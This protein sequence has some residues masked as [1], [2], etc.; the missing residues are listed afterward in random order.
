MNQSLWPEVGAEGS[1]VGHLGGHPWVEV[2][3]EE[4]GCPL[5]VEVEGNWRAGFAGGAQVLWNPWQPREEG[6]VGRELVAG[7]SQSIVGMEVEE[8]SY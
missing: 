8:G 5:Q 2:A 6:M 1:Q 3:V 7:E 4:G